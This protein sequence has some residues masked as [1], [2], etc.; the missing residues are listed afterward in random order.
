[1]KNFADNKAKECA[2][3]WKEVFGDSDEFISSFINEFYTA[4]NML[5]IEQDSKVVSMLHIVP[6]ELND[7]KVAYIY[8]VATIENERGKGHAKQLIRQAIE[9][10]KSEGY[11]AIFTLPADDGLTSFYSQFGFKGRY[12]VTFETKNGFDFGTGNSERDF[13]MALPLEPSW[14]LE[15]QTYSLR[16]SCS[17]N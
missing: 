3:L 17:T 16:M 6:F 7:S 4:D 5:C 13:V 12:A 2:R 15:P 8:A 1:M 14:G 9:K 11:K 10:A